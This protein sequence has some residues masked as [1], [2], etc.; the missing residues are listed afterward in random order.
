MVILLSTTLLIVFFALIKNNNTNVEKENKIFFILSAVVLI[1]VA[2]LR[3]RYIGT[4]DTDSYATTFENLSA[5]TSF[6]SYFS[7]VY[8]KGKPFIFSEAAF[9]LFC[10]LLGKISSNP[11]LLILTTSA[12]NI[13]SALF[14]IKNNSK[15]TE[16]STIGYVCLGS[17]SFSMNGMRQALAMSMCLL[18][19]EFVKRKKFIPFCLTII[20]ATLFHKTAFVFL[21]VYFVYNMKWNK[22]NVTF[23]LISLAAFV[24]FVN[25]IAAVFD[26]LVDKNYSEEDSFSSGGYVSVLIYLL[27]IGITLLNQKLL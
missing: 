14:F 18:G 15:N 20:L 5:Y 23:L 17:F 13:L 6:G 16:I 9:H 11:Q 7:G 2:G 10:Y 26:E 21:I 1:L 3:S 19:Y 25:K 27:C 8:E 4:S 12:I 24:L 22:I